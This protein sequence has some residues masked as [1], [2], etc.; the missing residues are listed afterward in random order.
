MNKRVSLYLV[1][2]IGIFSLESCVSNYVVSTPIKHKIEKTT[3]P[4]IS[5]NK[6]AQAN[7]KIKQKAEESLVSLAAL[8]KAEMDAALREAEKRDHTIDNILQQA[9][10]YLGTPYRLGGMTRKGID[11]S[12]FVL[13]VYNEV[14]GMKLPRVAASQANEGESIAKNELQKGDLIFFA[15]SGRGRISHVGIVEE[16]LPDGE[17]KFIHASSSRGVMVSSLDDAY[18]RGRYRM[19]KRIIVDNN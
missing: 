10:T 15:R 19:A 7:K 2:F 5:S 9:Y 3:L 17:I 8:E 12:A 1:A 16:V 13:S 6:L 11:C 14:T 4:K 18:W